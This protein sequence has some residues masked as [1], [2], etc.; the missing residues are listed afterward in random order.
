MLAMVEDNQPWPGSAVDI[1]IS[2]PLSLMTTKRPRPIDYAFSP[3]RNIRC[4][5]CTHKRLQAGFTELGL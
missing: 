5:G 1:L 2:I 3:N 4:I